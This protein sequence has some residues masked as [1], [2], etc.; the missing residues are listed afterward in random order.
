[1]SKPIRAGFFACVL[2]C[3]AFS[4]AAAGLSPIS[5]KSVLGQPFAAE[6][7]LMGL[8]NDDML[9]A[10][11]KIASREEYEKAGIPMHALIH[12]MR[13][14]IEERGKDKR[15]LRISGSA[16]VNEPTITIIVEFSWRGGRILQH[17]P[18][19]LDPPKA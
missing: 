8:T 12:Q 4:A 5:I 15:L 2:L 17:Y 16:P 3:A 14:V 7:E 13:V 9:T 10:Q 11:T 18:V 6:V 19:L 1:M